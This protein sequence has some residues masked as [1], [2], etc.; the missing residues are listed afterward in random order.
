ML[1]YPPGEL[2]Q[3]G[4]DRCQINV[5]ASCA[6]SMRA[7]ND[8]GIIAALL[9][10]EYSIFLKDYQTEKLSVDVLINDF[11]KEEP[12]VV[13]ISTTNGSIFEDLKIIK[14][15]K[16][17]NNETII[18]LKGALFFN[19]DKSLFEE[20]DLSCIDYLIGSEAE[21][22][23]NSLLTAHFYN[24]NNLVNIEGI[25]YKNRGEWKVN[26]ILHFNEMLDEI[27]FPDRS[28]MDNTLY[29]NPLTNKPMATI[30]TSKGCPSSCIYCLSPIISGKKVRYR[31]CNNIFQELTECV[32]KY[33]I[34]DFFFKADTFTIEKQKVI[35]LCDMIINSPLNGKITWCANSRVNTLDEDMIIKMKEAGCNLIALG[36]ES[37][38]KDSLLRMKKGTTVQDNISA[39][40]L[41]KKYNISI[42][43]FY[44]V[45]FPWETMR[46]LKETENLIFK[47]NTDFIEISI[48]TPFKQTEL[49]KIM[50]QNENN[51]KNV[52]G[53]DSFKNINSGTNC[54]SK[55]QLKKYRKNL[56]LKYYM[57]PKYILKKLT[58]KNL[59][60]ELL[61]NY[62][63]YGLRLIKK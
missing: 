27:P 44:L 15:L 20:F 43:G 42:F 33:N 38:S 57:R 6:N 51:G 32:E 23:I 52:L 60:F 36:I 1:I 31:S 41:I 5:E 45:G 29:I 34:T 63:K 19:P 14:I 47:L 59:S 58:D 30:T 22:I 4:E 53:K 46:H 24:K 11:T 10:K 25:C 9:K 37:G 54:V 18:I 7:C 50:Y 48:V 62:I 35:E 3:R 40:E 12:D 21:F 49:Y 17:I 39:V 26:K 28:L 13:F 56:I 16:K 55:N 61:K 2:Y 8:L